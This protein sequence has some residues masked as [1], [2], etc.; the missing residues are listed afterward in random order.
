MAKMNN[1]ILNKSNLTNFLY[2]TIVLLG[3]YLFHVTGN[4]DG[5]SNYSVNNFEDLDAVAE[6]IEDSNLVNSDDTLLQP[7]E[8]TATDAT[9]TATD[10]TATATDA[11]A[12]ATDATD[13]DDNKT[14]KYKKNVNLYF[15]TVPIFVILLT[16]TFIYFGFSYQQTFAQNMMYPQYYLV[17]LIAIIFFVL[18]LLNSIIDLVRGFTRKI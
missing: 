11:I 5:F 15:F 10:A 7:R 1:K 8:T 2:V 9:T 6:S 12:T 17:V 13:S 3:L 18:F 4:K 14:P 16:I